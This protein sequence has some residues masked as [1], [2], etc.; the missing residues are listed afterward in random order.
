MHIY[1]YIYIYIFI[2]TITSHPLNHLKVALK[3]LL[4]EKPYY[5]V[6]QSLS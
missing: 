6:V 2:Y 3:D 1:I 5:F 4:K